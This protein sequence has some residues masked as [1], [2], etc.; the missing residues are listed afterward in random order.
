MTPEEEAAL[1]DQVGDQIE[2]MAAQAFAQYQQLVLGGMKPQEA[3]QQVMS[4]FNG[5]LADIMAAAFSQVL[6]TA[7]TAES[8]LAMKV[9]TVELS[10][11]L[12]A[13]AQALSATVQGIVQR[14]ADGFQDARSLALQLYE[15]YDFKPVEVLK[16]SPTNDRITKYLREALLPELSD[17]FAS[18]FAKIQV[19]NLTTP[20]L[21]AAY[22][23]LLQAI[24]ALE[25]GA[26][27]ELLTNRLRVAFEEK[28]RYLAK[29]IAQT[30]LHRA[31]AERQAK[32]LMDDADVQFV[33]WRMSQTHPREDIC[34]FFA[35]VNA[36]GL[37][38]GVYP[39]DVAPVP[40]AHPF[41]R[42]ILA[43]RLD[44]YG[45]KAKPN[46][47]AALAY[48]A[49]LD[50]Q[51]AARIAGSRANL[52]DILDGAD[53]TAVHNEGIPEPY[54]VRPVAAVAAEYEAAP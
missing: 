50:P 36:Y 18:V 45:K 49:N 38:P 39:K 30:E 1:L 52:Q 44:L 16:F 42:C 11:R 23:E 26:G 10:Q 27:K 17:D 47:D 43:P 41:C 9:G 7:V 31:Y 28:A 13:D 24:D 15:G 8:V 19:E 34:D 33:Q 2:E 46:G 35:G 12:Y 20:A 53:P 4:S 54:R 25:E 37:G 29:R 6:V 48:F 22:S 32:E 21:K 40:T 3:V 5:D 14:H 51:E